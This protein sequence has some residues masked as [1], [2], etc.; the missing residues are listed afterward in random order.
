MDN[1]A[2]PSIALRNTLPFQ[3]LHRMGIVPYYIGA[4]FGPHRLCHKL[5]QVGFDV[6]E[7]TAVMHCPRVFAVAMTRVLERYGSVKAQR[8][9]LHYLMIF[10]RL[11]RWPTRFLTGYFLAVKAIKR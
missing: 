9:L 1:L 4:T 10:E 8:R 2:N 5:R 7:N 11:A 6:I 3:L